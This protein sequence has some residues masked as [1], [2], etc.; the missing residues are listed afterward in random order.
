MNGLIYLHGRVNSSYTAAEDD[1]FVLSSPQFGQ[2]YLADGWATEFVRSVIEKYLVVFIGYGADDP[3]IQYLLEALTIRESHGHAVYAFQHGDSAEA[4]ARWSHK[5]VEAIP[6][7]GEDDHRCLWDSL[8]DW[9]ERAVAPAQW[10]QSI[11]DLSKAGPQALQPHRRGQVAHLV[12][13]PEGARLFAQTDPPPPADWLCT[14]DPR[15][16]YAT[17]VR[18]WFDEAAP[19][20]DPFPLFSLDSDQPPKKAELGRSLP[21]REVPAGMWDALRPT[22]LDLADVD[23]A[24]CAS[25]YGPGS[26]ATP[27]LPPR[28]GHLGQWISKVADQ[29]AALWWAVRK[30]GL[31]PAIQR[32]IKWQLDRQPA[33]KDSRDSLL[34]SGWNYLFASWSEPR[35]EDARDW[36]ELN[37]RIKRDGWDTISLRLYGDHFRPWLTVTPSLRN[38][39]P[40]TADEKARLRDLIHLDVAYADVPEWMPVPAEFLPDAIKLLRHDLEH[41]VRLERELGNYGPHGI[42]PIIGDPTIADE[43]TYERTHGLS[44]LVLLFARL[45]GKLKTVDLSAAKREFDL[46][47]TDDESVFLRLRVWASADDSLVSDVEFQSIFASMGDDAFWDSSHQRDVLLAIS[48]RWPK[49][50]PAARGLI[51]HRLGSDDREIDWMPASEVTERKAWAALSRIEWL[52]QI[53]C[54][55]GEKILRKA[56]ELRGKAP[57]WSPALATKAAESMEGRGGT[58]RTD[59]TFDML[60]DLPISE[61]LGA[62]K[63]AQGRTD[64][65]LVEADPFR[66][67]AEARPAR[68]WA[69]LV[70]ALKKDEFPEWAW[71]TFLN[72]DARINDPPRMTLAIARRLAALGTSALIEISHPAA[73]WLKTKAAQL[74]EHAQP[75]FAALILNFESA[76]TTSADRPASAV[77]RTDEARDWVFEAINSPA[78]KLAESIMDDPRKEGR[79]PRQGFPEEWLSLVEATLRLPGDHGRYASVIY[80]FNLNWFYAI[81]PDW[82]SSH[83]IALATSR[84]PENKDAFWTGFFWGSKVPN[85][86]LYRVLKS[87]LIAFAKKGVFA[88]RGYGDVLAG[89]LLAGWGTKPRGSKISLITD[90]EMTSILLEADESFRTKILRQLRIWL[91]GGDGSSRWLTLAP[92]FFGTVWPKQKFI[93]TSA[94]SSSLVDLLFTSRKIF[95]R[96]TDSV[97]PLLT[98]IE[99]AH[100]TTMPQLRMAA[101]RGDHII[102]NDP[103]RVL[104]VMYAI[105]PE[106]PRSWPYEADKVVQQ[107]GEVAED[108][109]S[110]ARLLEITRRWNSR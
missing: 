76:L 58:V 24:N 12:S 43:V 109:K 37:R 50:T 29:P 100:F 70:R 92:A 94:I 93:R 108:L 2:A 75:T 105:L 17:P 13:T 36:Y 103:E 89:V 5:G 62:A 65:F 69:A 22:R 101:R 49:L 82:T 83:L 91:S 9:A 8:S 42:S 30:G 80:C 55:F 54:E 88:R 15:Q 96:L 110:D 59:T 51:E 38:P 40:P 47:P 44:G 81:A 48:S 7:G 77:S 52:Q 102:G 73:S 4:T 21:E 78:G 35:P 1:G 26:L 64:D 86:Q 99:E 84:D 87:P 11:I 28:L 16:R 39:I 68:A 23:E 56:H 10:S 95:S 90:D 107:I 25:A 60:A 14:F 106:D 66:G 6:Y 46:W 32:M 63:E 98:T 33:G 61:L 85:L 104:A 3:P 74:A 53:G 57:D 27:V 45:F 71:R 31:H 79:K 34:R 72:P 67:F 97:L 19:A 18:D 20:A 41:A